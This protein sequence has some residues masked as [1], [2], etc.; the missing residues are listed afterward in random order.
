MQRYIGEIV[1]CLVLI[2][3]AFA[4]LFPL[5]DI[6]GGYSGSILTPASFPEL[7]TWG[8]IVLTLINLADIFRKN[9]HLRRPSE[10]DPGV[11]FSMLP[12]LTGFLLITELVLYALLLEP[13]G[14]ILST[15]IFI[16][17]VIA[18][19]TFLSDQQSLSGLL[20]PAIKLVSFAV[21]FSFAVFY[22]F[23]LGFELVLP[24]L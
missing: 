8:I 24:T 23:S 1:W 13:A 9:W 2:A 3:L 20:Y 5:N 17:V 4:A 11:A 15:S 18:T 16:V 14:Y 19:L 22:L 12:V 10:T 21:L 7:I 6:G